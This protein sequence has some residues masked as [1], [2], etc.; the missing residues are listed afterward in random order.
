MLMMIM[1]SLTEIK[2][3]LLRIEQAVGSGQGNSNSSMNNSSCDS[4]NARLDDLEAERAVMETELM[5]LR[6]EN[7]QHKADIQVLTQS[8]YTA[9][10]S[11]AKLLQYQVALNEAVGMAYTDATIPNFVLSAEVIKIHTEA[12]FKQN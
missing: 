8:V 11:L 10:E 4:N 6:K 9:H 1:K 7:E 12:V 2:G 3:T 5:R